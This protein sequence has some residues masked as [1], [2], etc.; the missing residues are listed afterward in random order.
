MRSRLE[1]FC[2]IAEDRREM[3]AVT[4]AERLRHAS[5]RGAAIEKSTPI[6]PNGFRN[7]QSSPAHVYRL[8]NCC[9][10]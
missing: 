2:G 1:Y 6:E 7:D 4:T 8:G 10:C 9:R 5:D 3:F